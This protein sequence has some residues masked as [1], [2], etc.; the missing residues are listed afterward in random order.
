VGTSLALALRETA[1]PASALREAAEVIG[2]LHR[3]TATSR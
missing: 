3:A 1:D 2:F